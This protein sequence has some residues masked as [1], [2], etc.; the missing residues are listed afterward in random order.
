MMQASGISTISEQTSS[1]RSS[2]QN[3]KPSPK[4]AN[5]Q[6]MQ[7][8]GSL[9]AATSGSNFKVVIRVRPPLPRERPNGDFIPVV[10]VSP[11]SRSIAIMEYLG[12][13]IDERERGRDI[14]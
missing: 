8:T 4:P 13:E 12:Q 9:T 5:R 11:D 7:Q 2:S 14:E 1:M 6:S 10:E 3:F